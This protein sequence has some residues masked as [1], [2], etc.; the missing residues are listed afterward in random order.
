MESEWTLAQIEEDVNH[1][2]S[3]IQMAQTSFRNKMV[4]R[5]RADLLEKIP[6]IDIREERRSYF[7][8]QVALTHELEGILELIR[9]MNQHPVQN[10]IVASSII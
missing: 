1:A 8:H 3:M 6:Y 5:L 7:L 2:K 10:T 4:R 9:E